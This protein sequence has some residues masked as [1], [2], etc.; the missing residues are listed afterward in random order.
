MKKF[1]LAGKLIIV[2]FL[3]GFIFLLSR[4]FET[5]YQIT[6]TPATKE[7]PEVPKVSVDSIFSQQNDLSDLEEERLITLIATGDVILARG[8][9]WPAV[10]KGDFTYNWRKVADLLK[11]GDITLINLEA[12]LTKNCPL[13]TEGM[14]FCGDARHTQGISYAGV[15]SVSL[16]NNHI[17][18]YGQAGID[19][20]ISLFESKKIGWSG[21]GNLDIQKR[22][23]ARFGFL[24]Y[25]GISTTFD[26][27]EIAAE[28]NQMKQK[29]DVLVVSAHWGDEYVLAPRKYGNIAPDNPKEIGHLMIDAGADLIIGNHPHTVQG[30]EIYKNKLIAYAHG[31]FI[32]DQ[33]WSQETQ[34]GVVGE[35]TFYIPNES[36]TKPV[37]IHLVNVTY[38]PTL[39]DTSYQPRFLSKKKGQHILDRMLSSSR[40]IA[41][42]KP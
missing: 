9:N 34:E 7:P 10:T 25:N 23:G 8:A 42:S 22:G 5:D 33:T 37:T 3:V 39:V 24:A 41:S 19:E 12:P 28:I 31:N 21:F 16:A 6:K 36:S 14:I 29:V 40:Q 26:R 15:D 35:Y 2:F 32:F 30:V 1:I 18:N 27:K 13:K 4:G 20:T 17:G 11:K 38:H